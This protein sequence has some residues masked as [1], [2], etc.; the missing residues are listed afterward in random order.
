M[1]DK[2]VSKVNKSAFLKSV[3]KRT[4]KP[5]AEV[6]TIYDGMI[7]ELV[8]V[9]KSKRDLSLTGVGKFYV[10]KHKGHPV[11]FMGASEKVS[12]YELLKFS[13]ANIMNERLRNNNPDLTPNF[14]SD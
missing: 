10:Q 3:A 14:I 12:D 2:K 6:V 13:A 11:Q 7:D 1:M 4:G 9:A 8:D 5:Y